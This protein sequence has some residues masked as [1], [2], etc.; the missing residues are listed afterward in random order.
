MSYILDALKKSETERK[1][2][3]VPGL[4]SLPHSESLPSGRLQLWHVLLGVI[5][6]M[7]IGLLYLLN[8]DQN[9]PLVSVEKA[10]RQRPLEQT[11]LASSTPAPSIYSP[12]RATT[13][14]PSV[15]S[16]SVSLP[17]S[18][19]SPATSAS[20]SAMALQMATSLT[21]TLPKHI[22]RQSYRESF[23]ALVAGVLSGCLLEVKQVN[24]LRK[25]KLANILCYPAKSLA[26]VKARKLTT[27]MV[28]SRQVMVGV[29]DA[30][31]SGVLLVDLFLSDGTLLN[32]TLVQR[33]FVFAI[34]QRFGLE[35]EVARLS[36]TG[37]WQN[38]SA[39]ID[40]P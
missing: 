17:T 33:G 39:W 22:N 25:I 16:S 32:R 23:S 37:M 36:A 11:N 35:Q 6:S 20:P 27:R 40:V 9:Q 24:L 3:K 13:L 1:V 38:H 4:D 34:D 5:I 19:S 10:D 15:P 30:E 18:V 21:P 31:P 29:R 7:A 8:R 26:G 28:F 14:V 12:L 2:G